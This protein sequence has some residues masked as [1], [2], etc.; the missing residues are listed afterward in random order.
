MNNFKTLSGKIINIIKS[1]VKDHSNKISSARLQSYA[2][3]ILIYIFGI[4]FLT[5]EIIKFAHTSE[6]ESFEF[7]SNFLVIFGT[8]ASHHLAML[9]INKNSKSE[10]K[11]TTINENYSN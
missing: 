2:F 11:A 4:T 3:M 6:K 5:I 9:G 10:P 8:I 1:S 7:S